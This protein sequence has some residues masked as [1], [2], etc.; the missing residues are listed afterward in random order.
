MKTPWH[1]LLQHGTACA[2]ILVLAVAGLLLLAVV[3]IAVVA[4]K[5]LVFIK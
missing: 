4:T 3:G 2:T 5:V 1:S